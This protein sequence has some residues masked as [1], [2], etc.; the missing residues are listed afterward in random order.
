M[1]NSN[2]I[3]PPLRRTAAVTATPATRA[4]MGRARPAGA[5]TRLQRSFSIAT[6]ACFTLDAQTWLRT[7][8]IRLAPSMAPDWRAISLPLRNTTSVGMLRIA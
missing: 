4:A 3:L 6:G 5:G 2:P 7:Q 8:P 1:H